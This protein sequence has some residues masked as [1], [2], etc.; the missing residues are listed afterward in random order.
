MDGSKRQLP[1][2]AFQQNEALQLQ[3]FTCHS[4]VLV[5]ESALWSFNV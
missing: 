3:F 5:Q 2:V 1:E 4:A